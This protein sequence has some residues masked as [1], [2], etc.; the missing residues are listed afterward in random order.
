MKKIV[1]TTIALLAIFSL[2]AQENKVVK[3]ETTIKKVVTKEG[4]QVIVKE[5]KNVEKEKGSVM[6]EG[7]ENENQE[8]SEDLNVDKDQEVVKDEVII[9]QDNEDLIE[10]EKKQQ[11][12]ALQK[13]IEAQNA[14]AEAERKLLE[15][16]RE[17]RLKMME[18]NRKKLESRPKGMTKLQKKKHN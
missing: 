8:F 17:E 9:D 3:E 18:E 13:S 15:Q 14:K 16:Q 4:S 2:Q 7:N 1:F 6:V 11:E 12:D 5:V 10:A